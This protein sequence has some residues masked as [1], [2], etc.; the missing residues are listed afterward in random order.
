MSMFSSKYAVAALSLIVLQAILVI[1]FESIVINYHIDLISG[2]ELSSSGQGVSISDLIYHGILMVAQLF[3]ILLCLD[4]LY[5]R[6]SAQLYALILFD[7]SIVVY[8]V[9]QIRQ[10]IV[11]EEI[12]CPIPGSTV[13]D[14]T[15]EPVAHIYYEA[16]M[17]PYEYTIIVIIPASFL[18]LSYIAWHLSKNFTWENYR[19]YSADIQVRNAAVAFAIFLTL[20]KLDVFFVLAFATQLIPSQLLSYEGSV[21]ETVS[22]FVLGSA[23]MVLGF[24]SVY[25]ESKYGITAFTVFAILSLAYFVWKLALVSAPHPLHD[26]DPYQF[27]RNFLIFTIVGCIFLLFCS[28]FNAIVCFRNMIRGIVIFK[29]SNAG[30]KTLYG[31]MPKSGGDPAV[32]NSYP[33]ELDADPTQPSNNERNPAADDNMWTIE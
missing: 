9:I 26:L 29:S 3:Q 15:Q 21:S 20:L 6:N 8:A 32:F 4:A 24:I 2:C 23:L 30:S 12:G 31:Q 10:H 1:I 7:L 17:R 11:L 27:T 18:V 5:Q 33:I 28:I 16:L 13:D 25:R 19:S 22:V 14:P